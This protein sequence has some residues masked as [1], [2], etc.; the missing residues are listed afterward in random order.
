MVWLLRA[1]GGEEE[2]QVCLLATEDARS[3]CLSFQGVF[4]FASSYLSSPPP[5]LGAGRLYLQQMLGW[6]GKVWAKKM[7]RLF[8]SRQ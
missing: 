7:L 5:G 4:L 8:Y 2:A 3:I 6:L 1:E